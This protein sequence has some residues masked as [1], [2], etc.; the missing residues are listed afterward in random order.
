MTQQVDNLR[1]HVRAAQL[2]NKVEL[3]IVSPMLR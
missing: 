3:V 1:N 2:L